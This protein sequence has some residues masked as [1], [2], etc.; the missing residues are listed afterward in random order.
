M[1]ELWGVET[2]VVNDTEPASAAKSSSLAE[3]TSLDAT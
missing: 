3:E 2:E 1:G